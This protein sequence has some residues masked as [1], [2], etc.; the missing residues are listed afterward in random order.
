MALLDEIH[1]QLEPNIYVLLQIVKLSLRLDDF[2][3][4]WNTM[5]E[6]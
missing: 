1:Q 4:A 5:E 6:L 3:R 2:E